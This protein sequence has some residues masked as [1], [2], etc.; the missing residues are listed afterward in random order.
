MPDQ[1]IVVDVRPFDCLECGKHVGRTG[2]RAAP[3]HIIREGQD[4]PQWSFCSQ[5]CS[6]A[7]TQRWHAEHPDG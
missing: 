1:P 3:V 7:Y 4:P 6:A 2:R 5:K